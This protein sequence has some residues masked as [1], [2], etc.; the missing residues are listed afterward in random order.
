MEEFVRTH[1]RV[2]IMA[3]VTITLLL[4][5]LFAC[6]RSSEKPV[7][8][9][10]RP[11]AV[12]DAGHQAGSEQADK[13][14]NKQEVERSDAGQPASQV[15]PVPLIPPF[16]Q[17]VANRMRVDRP[18]TRRYD[19]FA[20]KLAAICEQQ[21]RSEEGTFEPTIL[22]QSP[23]PN[24][25]G[26]GEFLE[27]EV[28]RVEPLDVAGE[29]RIRLFYTDNNRHVVEIDTFAEE[30][31]AW[32]LDHV[33]CMEHSVYQPLC[34]LHEVAGTTDPAK[35]PVTPTLDDF[36]AA[37]LKVVQSAP[38]AKQRETLEYLAWIHGMV[39]CPWLEAWPTSLDSHNSSKK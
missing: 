39:R 38:R 23:E 26:A 34:A 35:I 24:D 15:V 21:P 13:Q 10:E 32:K 31:G 17:Q 12:E 29:H 11:P 18:T 5:G 9:E 19:R 1:F 20:K 7:S 2:V 22:C 33:A 8:P 6:S 25:C 37:A 3:I 28:T 27:G 30:D 36:T 16:L 4:G 14:A